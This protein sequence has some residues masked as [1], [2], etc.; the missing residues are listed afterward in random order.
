MGLKQYKVGKSFE[1]KLC[2]YLSNDGYYIIYNEKRGY[3]QST[4]RYC[5]NKK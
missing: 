2:W 3:R 5:C 4:S 1:E